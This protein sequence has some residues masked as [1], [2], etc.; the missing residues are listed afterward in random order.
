[1][2]YSYNVGLGSDTCVHVFFCK[3][4][5]VIDTTELYSW[6]PVS[7]TLTF[8]FGQGDHKEARVCADILLYNGIKLP[9]LF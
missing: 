9:K 6:I 2:K 1:M 8:S 3:L 7:V 4:C 5:V